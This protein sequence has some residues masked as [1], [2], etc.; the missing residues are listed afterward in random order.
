MKKL[1]LIIAIIISINT[2]AQQGITVER[3]QKHL[4]YLAS[5]SLQGRKTGT[6]YDAAAAKYIRNE[7]KK[8]GL[9]MM[10]DDGFQKYNVLNSMELASGNSF[11]ID[12]FSA[13]TQEDNI[14]L[15]YS[16]NGK[17]DAKVVFVGYGFT[18]DNQMLKRDDYQNIDVKGKWVMI[19]RDSPDKPEADRFEKYSS[20][21]QKINT[22]ISKGAKG[23]LLVNKINDTPDKLIPFMYRSGQSMSSILVINIS[24]ALADKILSKSKTNISQLQEK[25]SKEGKSDAFI[26]KSTVKANVSIHKD[27]LS[28]QNVIAVLKSDDKTYGNQYIVVGAHFDHLGMGGYGSRTPDTIAVHN[29]ADDNASGVASLIVLAK[30]LANCKTKPRRSIIFIAFSG[31]E[32]GLLGSNYFVNNPTVDIN[33]IKLMINMDMIGRLED[34]GNLSILGTGTA[35]EFNQILD[36]YKADFKYNITYSPSGF[37]GSDQTSFYSK[38]IPVLFFHSGTHQEYHTPFDDIELIDFEAQKDITELVYKLILDFANR[39]SNL[40]YKETQ[41]KDKSSDRA[42]FKVTLGI[43]PAHADSGNGIK[44]EGVTENGPAHVAGIVKGDYI[45]EMDGTQISDIYEYMN[46]LKRMKKNTTVTVKVK[47]GEEIVKLDVKF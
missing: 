36:T 22:A 37:G 44:V 24:Q 32:M 6:I 42:S 1:T 14:P 41:S 43:M 38:G 26:T 30:N 28:T 25:I 2:Y 10:A 31:E 11:V 46:V 33:D 7:F 35:E 20:D 15:S 45:I 5:D 47:R 18:V 40:T 39:D 23:V 13:K 16:A 12:K 29:G 3:L 34:T 27:E 17:L 19:L 9:Q 8:S 4:E 21:K